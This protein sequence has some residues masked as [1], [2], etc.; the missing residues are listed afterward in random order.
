MA[1]SGNKSVRLSVPTGGCSNWIR[2]TEH[3][4]ASIGIHQTWGNGMEYQ[5]LKTAQEIRAFMSQ[6]NQG[7][8]RRPPTFQD[9]ADLVAAPCPPPWL[10]A[11]L[12]WWASSLRAARLV[13]KRRP[14]KAMIKRRLVEIKDAALLL[15]QAL[16]DTPTRKFLEIAPSGRIINVQADDLQELARRAEYAAASPILSTEAGKTKL[17]RGKALMSG[18]LSAKSY[19]A[20]MI[21]ETWLYFRHSEP[22]A[23]GR[24]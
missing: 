14:T 17:G 19:C 23:C 15:Q 24:D 16:T 1:A 12:E 11:H 8:S 13:D 5:H 2:Q 21:S 4:G 22:R 9:V 10:A 20:A 6:D 7:R 3:L 18:D